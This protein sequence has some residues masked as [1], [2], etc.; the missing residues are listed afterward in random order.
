MAVKVYSDNRN[1]LYLGDCRN[2]SELPD[3]S[4]HL[5]VTSPP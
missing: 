2:M 4:A 5:I 3:G 1:T